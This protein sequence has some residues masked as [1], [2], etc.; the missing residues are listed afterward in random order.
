MQMETPIHLT[1]IEGI[2]RADTKS[3][4][5]GEAPT[6]AEIP[7]ELRMDDPELPAKNDGGGG[8]GPNAGAAFAGDEAK[9]KLKQF[10]LNLKELMKLVFV[11]RGD[12]FFSSEMQ[13][14]AKAAFEELE[15]KL[16]AFGKI[17]DG[18][19][20]PIDDNLINEGLTGEQLALKLGLF[21][22]AMKG[23]LESIRGLPA[24]IGRDAL[25]NIRK[26]LK[27]PFGLA[28][29]ILD[30]VLDALGIKGP[31]KELLGLFEKVLE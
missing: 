20:G 5:V 23:I 25:D 17:L 3:L 28:G 9:K 24:R 6:I 10:V 11:E 26:N 16:D 14:H 8:L 2:N 19:D 22:D 18:L 27:K 13:G 15:G 12:A 1:R 21:D 29:P 31:T 30:S 4:G 7:G